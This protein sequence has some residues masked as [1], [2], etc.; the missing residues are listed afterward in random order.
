MFYRA[1]DA[2]SVACFSVAD[3]CRM[4]ADARSDS[5][6]SKVSRNPSGLFPE[7]RRRIAK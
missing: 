6:Q 7:R 5:L 4:A 2:L 1:P 3:A